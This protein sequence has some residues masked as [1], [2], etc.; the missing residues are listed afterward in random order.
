MQTKIRAEQT[1]LIDTIYPVGSIYMSV[2]STN[3]GTTF[4]VGTWTAW[5]EGR[6]PVGVASSG[7]FNTVEKTGGAETHTLTTDEMPSHQHTYYLLGGPTGANKTALTQ[8]SQGTAWQSWLTEAT[9]GGS[10][11]NNLQPYITCYMWKR[12]A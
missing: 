7:T 4:G 5:G 3:P 12:T 6:V 1:N 9:G 10:A 11:H 8:W 2:S